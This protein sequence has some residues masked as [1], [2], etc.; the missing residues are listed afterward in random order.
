M[1]LNRSK[2]FTVS[3]FLRFEQQQILEE[4]NP[5][6]VGTSGKKSVAPASWLSRTTCAKILEY[7]I[8]VRKNKKAYNYI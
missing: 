8:A 5:H 7:R 3:N 4:G 1:K 6:A 2:N